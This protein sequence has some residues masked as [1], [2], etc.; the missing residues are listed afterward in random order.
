MWR[1]RRKKGELV[2]WYKGGGKPS[3]AGERAEAA[4]ARPLV[5]SV[6]SGLAA[7]GAGDERTRTRGDGHGIFI[8]IATD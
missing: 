7:R 1:L 4:E 6:L 2:F 8:Q 3:L 5:W